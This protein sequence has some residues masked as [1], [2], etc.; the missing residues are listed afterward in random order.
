LDRRRKPVKQ[1]SPNHKAIH[2]SLIHPTQANFKE[3]GSA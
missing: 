3:K 1:L 2:Q